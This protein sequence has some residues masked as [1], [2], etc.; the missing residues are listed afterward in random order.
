[1]GR[2][3]SILALLCAPAWA[4]APEVEPD[5][6]QVREAASLD[7]GTLDRAEALFFEGLAHYHGG[8]FENAALRFQEAYVLT[9]HRDMLFNVARSR[10]RLG[11]GKGAV[12]WYRSYLNT[13]PTDETAVIHRVRQ[14]GGDPTP[15]EAPVKPIGP[16]APTGP[17]LVEVGAGPWPWVAAAA[18]V[19]ATATGVALGVAAL[20]DA[21]AARAASDRSD[22]Q[23]LKT[24]ATDGAL[25]ADVLYGVGAAGIGVAVWLFLRADSKAA[26]QGRMELSA[27]PDGASLGW[28]TAF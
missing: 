26:A 15:A 12:R 27:G 5:A 14:L 17:R 2:V 4:Q 22:A 25:V 9:G 23:R 11:D 8:R 19:A 21:E 20:A 7:E 1:M 24:S 3:V 28:S 13:R 10:E 18:G 16:R 6:T